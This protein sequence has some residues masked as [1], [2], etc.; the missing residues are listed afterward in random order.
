MIPA[1]CLDIGS[2]GGVPANWLSTRLE[3][4]CICFDIDTADYVGYE[5]INK[6][7]HL[8][9]KPYLLA[10][11]SGNKT[12]YYHDKGPSGSSFY[13]LNHIHEY[14]V[15]EFIESKMEVNCKALRELDIPPADLI[16][17]DVQGAEIDILKGA[18][19]KQLGRCFAIEIEVS[20][21][22]TYKGAPTFGDVNK[23]LAEKGFIIHGMRTSHHHST[24]DGVRIAKRYGLDP[25]QFSVITQVNQADCLYIRDF[26]SLQEVN[27]ET[28]HQWINILYMYRA[29]DKMIQLRNYVYNEL[30]IIS[31]KILENYLRVFKARRMNLGDAG[32]HCFPSGL[33]IKDYD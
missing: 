28:Y 18:S 8:T 4:N 25:E 22:D 13:P 23:F 1:V 16:K 12:F 11:Y 32:I 6:L 20:F 9:R 5:R 21:L 3:L 31:D 27:V 24:K 29:I 7:L 30:G 33:N 2:R 15:D 14:D 10:E 17:I 26:N 19:T